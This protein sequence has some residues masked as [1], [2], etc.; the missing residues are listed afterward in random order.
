MGK[1]W[2]K[3]WQ[4]ASV[5]QRG[6]GG[7]AVFS[8]LGIFAFLI[9]WV[10]LFPTVS[11]GDSGELIAAAYSR[12]VPHPPGYPLFSALTQL[13]THIPI[14]T[15]AWRANLLSA[16]CDSGAAVL[17]MLTVF[18]MSRNIWA[19]FLA[20]GLFAFSPLVWTYATQAEVFPL[21]NLLISLL[22]YLWVSYEEILSR[23]PP[24]THPAR[25]I[26][27]SQ[28][29][30]RALC[31]VMG[32]GMSNHHL[33]VLY[34]IPI[35]LRLAGLRRREGVP[36]GSWLFESW[37]W[38]GLGLLP[39]GWIPWTASSHNSGHLGHSGHSGQPAHPAVTWGAPTTVSGFFTH[40]LRKEYGTFH[41]GARNT[42]ADFSEGLFL[43]L[44]GAVKDSLYL[45]FP[46]A[47]Y[48]F[49]RRPVRPLAI[50]FA[51]YLV[52]F[53][54]FAN[55]ALDNSIQLGI[56]MRFWQQP[57]LLLF[58]AMGIGLATLAPTIET[59]WKHGVAVIAV[60]AVIIQAATHFQMC[61]QHRNWTFHRFGEDIFKAIPVK[62]APQTSTT[63]G[64]LLLTVGDLETNLTRYLQVCEGFRPDVQLMDRTL[65]GYD[66][67][68]KLYRES[69]PTVQFP[70]GHY[71][72]FVNRTDGYSF[73]SFLDG[74]ISQ[75]DI[76]AVTSESREER[77]WEK[78][79]TAWPLGL[80]NHITSKNHD[81]TLAAYEEEII[82]IPPLSRPSEVVPDT[83]TWD[84]AVW[85]KYWD[86]PHQR[87]LRF[88]TYALEHGND[89]RG[90]Q[91]A[92]TL[93]ED[94]I[95]QNP[96]PSARLFK[97]L[98]VV[99][100]WQA[101]LDPS[102]KPKLLGAWSRYLESNPVTDPAVPLIQKVVDELRA[103]AM[104]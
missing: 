71:R 83:S 37:G 77:E 51:T 50:C 69:F 25:K 7:A 75:F 13:F 35:G 62:P 66:W 47:I 104:H 6:T 38:F 41:L 100:Q 29:T 1:K 36:L 85:D 84:Y 46:L 67:G 74:N 22:L 39:Y 93:I 95:A 34:L 72:F 94:L 43:Y 91:S 19:G 88:L 60:L 49:T 90:L 4:Q 9:Y 55:L 92:R 44:K 97:N 23:P 80:I 30:R 2:K 48:G 99:Y 21:N 52:V 45:G 33:F 5:T 101:A 26:Q 12:G 18:Q 58:C 15:I 89:A 59:R 14:G 54:S 24:E 96:A 61:D 102:V 20:G 57:Q 8:I 70:P 98:G 86:A 79:Y 103:S 3:K 28:K 53:F 10:T 32:L 27:A 81:L 68:A 73:E 40:V 31:L 87:A 76:F 42:S 65:M 11:G 16:V 64:T 78:S 17:L 56:F 82:R 63:A